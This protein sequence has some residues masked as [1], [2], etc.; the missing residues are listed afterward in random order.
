MA[1]SCRSR[2]PARYR[3]DPRLLVRPPP[4]RVR[5]VGVH[6]GP[7][8]DLWW[9]NAIVYCLDV[10]TFRRRTSPRGLIDRIDHV[11]G[12]GATCLWLMPLYPTPEPRR[13]LRHHRLP[14]RRPAPRRP[15]RRRGGDPPRERPRAARARRPRRQPHLRRA[16][17]VP[18]RP[19][20]PRLAATAPT[21]SGATTRARAGHDAPTRDWTWDASRPASTTCTASRRSSPTS[22]SRTRPCATRS[23]RSSGSGSRSACPASAWTPSRSCARRSAPATPTRTR[24]SAGC[25]RCASTRRAGAARRC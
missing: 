25:T 11:A 22:T 10:E 14:R 7:T 19:R 12:L 13:R 20:G 15:R 16:P 9:K 18:R 24:A 1:A 4:Q 23:R 21:T 5:A 2:S 8:S 17:L 6:L 3:G